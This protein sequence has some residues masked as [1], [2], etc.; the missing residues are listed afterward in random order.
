MNDGKMDAMMEGSPC[1]DPAGRGGSPFP[2]IFAFTI[3]LWWCI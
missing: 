3:G 1:Y 2:L